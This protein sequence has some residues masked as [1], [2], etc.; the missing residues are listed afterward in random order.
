MIGIISAMPEEIQALLETLQNKKF[1]KK[2]IRTYY[3]G[4]LFDKNVVLVFFSLGKSGF[5]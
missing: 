3:S 4:N 1:F 5:R 2:E